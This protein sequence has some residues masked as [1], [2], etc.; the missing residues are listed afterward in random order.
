MNYDEVCLKIDN[1]KTHRITDPLKINK[2]PHP[3]ILQ[4]CNK[5]ISVL[6]ILI[7]FLIVVFVMDL[8]GTITVTSTFY[9]LAPGSRKIST[10]TLIG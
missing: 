2:V 8:T 7:I 3:S 4:V 10:T 1:I 5:L 6:I 9:I